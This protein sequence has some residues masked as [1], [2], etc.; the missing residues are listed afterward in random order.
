MIIILGLGNPGDEYEHTRHNA[1]FMAMDAL[2]KKQ[3]ATWKEA[4]AFHGWIAETHIG[5]QKVLLAKPW[6]YMNASG[7][8][9]KALAQFYKIAPSQIIVVADDVSLPLGTLRVRMEGSAGGHNGLK[10]IIEHL[11]TDVFP[12]IKIG[13]DAEPANVPLEAWVLSRFSKDEVKLLAPVLKDVVEVLED[14][15]HSG[16][17]GETRYGVS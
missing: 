13:V 3:N 1:G 15:A 16:L 8:T 2:A 6:T 17:K 4:D 14:A 10:S 5:E 7:R 11:G 12:R 9:A